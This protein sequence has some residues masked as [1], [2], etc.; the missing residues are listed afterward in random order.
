MRLHRIRWDARHLG[1]LV[2]GIAVDELQR[3]AGPLI[4]LQQGQRGV[5]IHFQALTGCG[6]LTGGTDGCIQI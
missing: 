3:D 4:G 1:D 5:D 6:R 2:D